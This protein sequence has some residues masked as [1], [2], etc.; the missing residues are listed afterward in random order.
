MFAL[1]K[2]NLMPSLTSIPEASAE[3]VKRQFLSALNL[4]NFEELL[5]IDNVGSSPTD[6]PV[7]SIP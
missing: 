7:Q 5:L 3:N 6:I 1:L 4:D 2:S